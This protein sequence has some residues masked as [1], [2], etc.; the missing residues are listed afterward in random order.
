MTFKEFDRLLKADGWELKDTKGLHFQYAHP[1]KPG[2]VTVP[3]HKG[4]IPKGTLNSI[5]RQAGLK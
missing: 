5:L 2:K 1:K 4:D 3:N